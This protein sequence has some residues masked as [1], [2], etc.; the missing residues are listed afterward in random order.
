MATKNAIYK[1]DNGTDFD[2]IMFKTIATQVG[3]T[4]GETLQAWINKLQ[5][6][7][8]DSG[9][10]LVEKLPD[11][12]ILQASWHTIIAA[13]GSVRTV[14]FAQAF[15]NK[16]IAVVAVPMYRGNVEQIYVSNVTNS[17]F[18][19]ASFNSLSHDAYGMWIAIGY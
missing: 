2:E 9:D 11:G 1:V 17:Y 4:S 10:Y 19:L 7:M 8:Y 13:S 12:L 3:L 15:P 5:R 14:N 18:Q 16:C 6:S